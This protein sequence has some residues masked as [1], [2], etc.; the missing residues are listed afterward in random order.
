MLLIK[1]ELHVF[2]SFFSLQPLPGPPPI[3]LVLPSPQVDL[4]LWLLLQTHIC[5]QVCFA[6]V[7]FEAD[8][9]VL[10]NQ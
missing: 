4:F 9:F 10:D 6:C 2:S 5:M 7:G 1:I 8:Y 3:L